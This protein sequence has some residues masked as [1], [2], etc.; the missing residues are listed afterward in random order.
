M[1]NHRPSGVSALKY[2]TIKHL[3]AV[4]DLLKQ[5]RKAAADLYMSA[6]S[7]VERRR[8]NDLHRQVLA[9]QHGAN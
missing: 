1:F 3:I 6:L 2:S 9:A 4:N 5:G 8:I 7:E